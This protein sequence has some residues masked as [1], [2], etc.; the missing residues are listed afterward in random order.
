MVW[1]TLECRAEWVSPAS[2]AWGSKLRPA[3]PAAIVGSGSSAQ[4]RVPSL[5]PLLPGLPV[6]SLHR[7]DVVLVQ[8]HLAFPLVVTRSHQG[9]GLLRVADA[10]GVAELVGGDQQQP[11]P[12]LGG[13][14]VQR[15]VLVIIKMRV[16]SVTGKEGVRTLAPGSVKRRVISVFSALKP[17]V[18]VDLARLLLC[19]FQV[20]GLRPNIE[21]FADN[22]IHRLFGKFVRVF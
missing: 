5:W 4:C 22:F 13:G 10:E 12:V 21:S 16:A 14:L 17:D 3:A 8:L 18:N 20:G 1:T 2:A 15:P 7:L 9:R 11:R 19:E 6:K